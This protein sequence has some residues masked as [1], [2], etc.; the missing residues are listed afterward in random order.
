VDALVFTGSNEEMFA[1]FKALMK[2]EFDMTDLGKMKFFLGVEVVQN[3]EGI[4]LSQNALE[5]L[6]RFGLENANSVRN[7]MVPS[8]KLMKN[9]DG[10]QVD[11]TQYKQMV[12]SFMYLSVN[13][14]DLMFVVSLVSRYMERPIS[15][16][17][18]AIKRVLRNVKGSVDLGI[19]YK[20]G[21]VSDEMLMAF[22]DSDYVGDQDDHRS[23]SGYV[24]MLN[25]GAVGWSLKK[26]PVVSLSILEA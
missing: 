16:H 19:C 8:I 1:E 22:S 15:L 6:E 18:Q 21:V 10:K 23:T 4:Y 11:M 20:R 12:C 2:R 14:S 25:G 9:E 13:R 24:L 3:D 7:L 5:I 26:Q 17:M